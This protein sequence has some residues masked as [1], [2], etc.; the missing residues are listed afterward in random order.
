[1][2][3]LLQPEDEKMLLTHRNSQIKLT[4]P[5]FRKRFLVEGLG[6]VKNLHSMTKDSSERKSRDKCKDAEVEDLR[7][8]FDKGVVCHGKIKLCVKQHAS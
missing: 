1:M 3:D 5:M 7:V 6:S 8:G 2:E 4:N